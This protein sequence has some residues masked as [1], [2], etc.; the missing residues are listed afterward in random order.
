[1]N[2]GIV[3]SKQFTGKLSLFRESYKKTDIIMLCIPATFRFAKMINYT[4]SC[5]DFYK[6]RKMLYNKQNLKE[7]DRE[8]Q[9]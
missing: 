7:L 8:V 5:M 9:S 3:S 1:M 2:V 6:N 4:N